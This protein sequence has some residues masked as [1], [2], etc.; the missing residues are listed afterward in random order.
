M[1]SNTSLCES[2]IYPAK[3]VFI[4]ILDCRALDLEDFDY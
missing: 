4:Y 3:K 2:E 1:Y